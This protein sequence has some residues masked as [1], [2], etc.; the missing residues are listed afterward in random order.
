MTRYLV[1]TNIVLRFSNPID[2]QHSLVVNAISHLG[3]QGNQCVLTAQVLME[4]W[5]VATRPVNVNGLG[6]STSQ[7]HDRI[8]ELLNGF[9][10]LEDRADIFPIWL[11][12]VNDNSIQGKRS[13]DIRLI[14]V[15]LSHRIDHLLTLNPTDFAVTAPI[16]VIHP[17]TVQ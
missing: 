4:F 8:V 6:W 14:A 5:V 15:M 10:L 2:A 7:T 3:L 13:H 9:S 11:Q 17:Q 16:T 12:L 1:D